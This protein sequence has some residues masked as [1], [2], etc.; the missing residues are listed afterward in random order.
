MA[1]R[2]STAVRLDC[3]YY[4]IKKK[5]HYELDQFHVEAS[6]CSP[7]EL[8]LRRAVGRISSR[9]APA[10]W[11]ETGQAFA[12]QVLT[13]SGPLTLEGYFQSE[14]YFADQR[15]IIVRDLS[16]RHPLS[17]AHEPLARQL[18][19]GESVCV[20]VRRGDYVSSASN[21]A[22]FGVLTP[23]FYAAAAQR[24]RNEV[25]RPRFF[26]FSDDEAWT[27]RHVL[28]ALGGSAQMAAPGASH[29]DHLSLMRRCRHF[30]LGNSTFSWW[31]AWLAEA[32]ATRIVAPWPWWKRQDDAPGDILPER[33]LRVPSQFE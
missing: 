11:R 20:H 3:S 25:P 5:R 29:L 30:I 9:L 28:P 6:V 10:E 24:L 26:I 14:R 17:S 19:A 2:Q 33:W 1:L 12:P 8:K 7:I 13:L 32:P 27:S 31:A 15:E 21:R 16:P 23:A 4:E 22:Q 18:S